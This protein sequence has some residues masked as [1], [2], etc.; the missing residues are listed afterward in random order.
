MSAAEFLQSLPVETATLLLGLALLLA[1][2]VVLHVRNI[3]WMRNL[4][5]REETSAA[6]ARVE[7]LLKAVERLSGAGK[8]AQAMTRNRPLKGGKRVP[9]IRSA[10]P[11]G[12][13]RRTR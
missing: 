9:A 7:K 6:R 10:K 13:I 5:T 11:Q 2:V 4:A 3:R 8:G 12:A 1:I